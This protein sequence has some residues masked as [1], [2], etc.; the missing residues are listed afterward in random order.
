[1]KKQFLVLLVSTCMLACV[2]KPPV[3]ID[4]APSSLSEFDFRTTSKAN[5]DFEFKDNVGN[6]I[7]K[8]KVEVWST[9]DGQKDNV[10]FKAFTDTQGAVSANLELPLH[11]NQVVVET[12]YV[13]IPNSIH[14]PVEN[15]GVQLK[16]VGGSFTTR[17]I[18]AYTSNS[19]SVSGGSSASQF[20][21][22][23]SFTI[24]YM[25]GYNSAGVP[26]YLEAERDAISST[27]LD[28]INAS[29]P[30]AQ[31]V[32]QY[33]PTYLANGKKTTLDIEEVCDVWLTFVHEGAGWRNAMAFYTYATN[34]PPQ[35]LDDIDEI[36]V[37]FPNLSYA[38]SGGGLSS[39]DKVNI[40]RFDPGTSV[41]LVLLAD[42][43]DGSNSEDYEHIVFADKSLNPEP[44]DE[45]K[46]H[47]V[48][49]W[50]S[51]NELFLVG[52]ED[53]RRD[54]IP[55]TCDQ[56]FNDAILFVTSNPVTGISTDNVSPIDQPD[57]DDTDGDGIN[58]ILDEYPNDPNKA[59][60]SYYPSSNTF[61]TFAFEDNWPD[62]G[63]YDFNDLVIDYQ[64]KH[65]LN[66]DNQVVE[67]CPKFKVR[68]IGAGYRNGF[69]FATN[70]MTSD[71]VST[72]GQSV[73]GAYV[74]LNSNGTES[75]QSNAVFIV[76]DNLHDHFSTG[77]FVNTEETS[78]YYDPQEI[79]L[80]IS[81]QSPKTYEDIG[82]VPYNPFLMISQDRGREVHLPGYEPTDLV[83][84]SYF[85]TLD[86]DTNLDLGQYYRSKTDL[87]WAIH[88]P[89]SFAYPKE[90]SDI[91]SGHI[92]FTDWARSFGFSYMDWYRNQ[93]G[94][95]NT[96]HLYNR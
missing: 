47:N 11:L 31:P 96:N 70:L 62:Y 84:S 50:D 87:P 49:L 36:N 85:G 4:E 1:M 44:D 64:F 92:R 80:Q 52:F 63:D 75:G 58:D 69:G 5:L 51:Q 22:T 60:D 59:Y 68:A 82:S 13:G 40:G 2:E 42:G 12:S 30:E 35:S 17:T 10:I 32:P 6:P 94:Y 89:E 14:V 93:D 61:G 57:T 86:D 8:V 91:R 3:D 33:H 39:G 88:L 78:A 45:L 74:T 38:G 66:A 25:G 46:Q 77:G 79:T 21:A 73:N 43:W 54:D 19:G 9:K 53:V 76:S 20:N 48:L 41:G 55:F 27:L 65:V 71:V 67:L 16:Y 81:F 24:N 95:R 29:L 37:I 23:N 26:N 28:Y 56:D 83:N 15:G 7:S 72:I 90:K 34:T 18:N